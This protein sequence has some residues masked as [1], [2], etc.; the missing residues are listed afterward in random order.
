MLT[1]EPP[2]HESLHPSLSA[3]AYDCMLLSK[4]IL[5]NSS[6]EFEKLIASTGNS[7]LKETYEE[8]KRAN[9]KIAK[10]RQT[11]SSDADLL[12]VLQLQQQN[13]KRQLALYRD[14]AE[15]ADFTDYIG[16]DWKAV[17]QRRRGD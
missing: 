8:A 7:E 5:L 6:I 15:I 1:M 2:V 3:L 13:Q 11:V 10:L 16:Y 9:E 4:G 14:C 17:Q 12:K